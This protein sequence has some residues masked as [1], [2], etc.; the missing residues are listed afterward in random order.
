VEPLVSVVTPSY[1]MADRIGRC[2]ESVSAQTYPNVEHIVVDGGSTDGTVAILQGRSG[3]RWSSEPDRGQ[4][5]AI[6]KG[7]AMAT[8]DVIGWL[9]ADDEIT[10]HALERVVA[11]LVAEPDAGLVY[12]DIDV[13]EAGRTRRLD[14]SPTFGMD[15]LWR[16]TTIWQPGTFWTRWAQEA[17]GEI[18]ESFNLAMDFEYWLRFAEAGIAGVHV[19]HVQAIFEI[20]DSSKT[21]VASALDFAEDEARALRKHGEIHGAAMAIDRWYWADVV[22]SV[23]EAARAGR[24]SEAS[25]MAKAA[26]RRMHPVRSRPRLFLWLAALSPRA[27]ARLHRAAGRPGA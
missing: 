9:N 25:A 24:A 13:V 26:I 12:G 1:G 11:A 4:S 16:G 3:L 20:H 10:P 23:G 19:P 2:L 8:G 5:H 17:V 21:G 6:N 27:A 7:L 22:Q 18:D 15:A 14:A